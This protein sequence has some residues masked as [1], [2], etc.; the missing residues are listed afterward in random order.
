MRKVY[1][2]ILKEHMHKHLRTDRAAMN[3]T[4]AQMAELLEMVP[5][6]YA[7]LEYGQSGASTVTMV[8]Y[9]KRFCPDVMAF[10]DEMYDAFMAAAKSAQQ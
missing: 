7:S 1:N 10:V 2:Q 3:L 5:R 8:L 4:L 6:S 9:L